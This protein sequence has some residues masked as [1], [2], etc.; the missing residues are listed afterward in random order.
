MMQAFAGATVV[1][2]P[3]HSPDLNPVEHVWTWMKRYIAR[4]YPQRPT[5][6]A[7]KEVVVEE[8]SGGGGERGGRGGVKTVFR[9]WKDSIV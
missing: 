6:N 4:K 2:W 9:R 7:L 3:A 5:G 8:E 1:V